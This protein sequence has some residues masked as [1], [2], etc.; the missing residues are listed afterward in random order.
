MPEGCDG[1]K[2]KKQQGSP[3]LQAVG[4]VNI[5]IHALVHEKVCRD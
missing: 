4:G 5:E 2:P 1:T 3:G